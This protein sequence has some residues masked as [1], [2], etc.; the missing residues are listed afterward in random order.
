MGI[1]DQENADKAKICLEM[2]EFEGR[3]EILRRINERTPDA[4]GMI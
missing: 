4:R 1:F 2:M 3:D